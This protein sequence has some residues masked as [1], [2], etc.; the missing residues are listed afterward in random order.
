VRACDVADESA[1]EAADSGG[2]GSATSVFEKTSISAQG[3][4]YTA[5]STFASPE[6]A[7]KLC[8]QTIDVVTDGGHAC[9]GDAFSVEQ[10][11]T[12]SSGARFWSLAC[13]IVMP[14]E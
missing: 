8:G 10:S 4:S 2:G 5:A 3:L 6:A 13:V 11:F 1:A 7:L 14:V 12:Q 9:S